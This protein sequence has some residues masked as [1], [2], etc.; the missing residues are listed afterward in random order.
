MRSWRVKTVFSSFRSIPTLVE[1]SAYQLRAGVNH[2]C[3]LPVYEHGWVAGLTD[4]S[5]AFRTSSTERSFFP[6][7][8][9]DVTRVGST[10][11]GGRT[12]I[13]SCGLDRCLYVWDL[14]TLKCLDAI[15]L[16]GIPLDL[17]VTAN[18]IAVATTS[19]AT[20]FRI[21]DDS[22]LQSDRAK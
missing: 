13:V 9:G 20:V 18:L 3:E 19:G 21:R 2:V 17:H 10:V 16:D 15:E 12:V 14:A 11:V 4:G 1:F 8:K 22:F 7:H 5:I 6:A